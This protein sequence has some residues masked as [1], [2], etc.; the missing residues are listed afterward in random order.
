[1]LKYLVF[2][3]NMQVSDRPSHFAPNL[4]DPV[5]ETLLFFAFFFL[6]RKPD[7]LLIEG[8]VPELNAISLLYLE[9]SFLIN[10]LFIGLPLLVVLEF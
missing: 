7:E 3:G 6:C 8:S 4:L 1:M 2:S 5:Y 10:S 9:T